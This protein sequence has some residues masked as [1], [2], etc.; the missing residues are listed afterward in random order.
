MNKIYQNPISGVNKVGFTLIEL[1]VVVLIIGIL[2]AVALPSYQRAVRKA[3]MTQVFTYLDGLAKAQHIFY[4]ANGQYSTRFDELDWEF[5]CAHRVPDDGGE[6]SDKCYFKFSAVS[7]AFKV[8]GS[9]AM[10][11]LFPDAELAHRLHCYRGGLN[12]SSLTYYSQHPDVTTCFASGSDE[13][14]QALLTGLGGI[15]VKTHANAGSCNKAP[16]LEYAM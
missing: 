5:P 6:A 11:A 12:G 10:A 16:C 4:L 13:E 2:A 8:N 9:G 3:Q 15:L 14:G 1:L 7:G